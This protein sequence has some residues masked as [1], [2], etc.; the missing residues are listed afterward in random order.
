M[1]ELRL[2]AGRVIT[3]RVVDGQGHGVAGWTVLDSP[4]RMAQSAP[5]VT[6][7][8]DGSFALFG[9]AEGLHTLEV[10]VPGELPVPP[11]ARV[12][13][14]PGD[15][16]EIVVASTAP[17]RSVVRGELRRRDG[18]VPAEL[19]LRLQPKD[20]QGALRMVVDPH[21]GRFEQGGLLPG[22]Y[23]LRVVEGNVLVAELPS[24][25]LAQDA[26][27]DIGILWVEPPG[28]VEIELVGEP[29]D[30]TGYLG[31]HLWRPNSSPVHLELD[32]NRLRA[33]QVP[34][35]TWE[36]RGSAA[37]RFLYP[38]QL[39]V[40]SG[41]ATRAQCRL[42]PRH[43]LVLTF[44]FEPVDPME[45]DL[46][47]EIVDELGQVLLDERYDIDSAPFGTQL[48]A[49][50]MAAW[51]ALDPLDASTRTLTLQLPPGALTV[52]AT[53]DHGRT[54]SAVALVDPAGGN[55]ADIVVR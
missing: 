49:V 1:C 17:P 25:T 31:L 26:P 11:R 30:P 28:A 48:H 19:A 33:D 42:A 2:D 12:R 50:R 35:G 16:V 3:G 6:T 29:P 18:G 4:P 55:A 14:R 37:E 54:A 36:V 32:G 41:D 13:A 10:T 51:K 20:F 46:R 22:E 9:V 39:E 15:D 7:G 38:V 24:V 43:D 44:R 53:T 27:R 21:S 47:L 52:R 45:R 5:S 40:R 8:A 23:S 34:P